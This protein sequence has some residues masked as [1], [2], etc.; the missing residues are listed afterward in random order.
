MGSRVYGL[1]VLG[2]RVE[3]KKRSWREGPA[4]GVRDRGGLRVKGVLA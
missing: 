1:R 2:L 4:S 3:C